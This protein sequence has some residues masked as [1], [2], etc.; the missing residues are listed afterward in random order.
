MTKIKYLATDCPGKR[1][2]AKV[3]FFIKLATVLQELADSKV[4]P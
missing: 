3:R 4:V 2:I 1:G